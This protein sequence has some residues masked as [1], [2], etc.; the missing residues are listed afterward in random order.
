MKKV[1]FLGVFW[2][3]HLRFNWSSFRVHL[4]FVWVHLG[5]I[6]VSLKVRCGFFGVLFG[7]N[8]G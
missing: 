2:S 1:V 4:G 3:R 7:F 8:Q 5:F 6:W